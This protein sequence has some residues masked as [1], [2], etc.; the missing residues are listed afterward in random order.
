MKR[1]GGRAISLE[2]AL[3]GRTAL[4]TGASRGIG[5]AIARQLS[6]AG[7]RVALLA[8]TKPALEEIAEEIG[9]DAVVIESDLAS[10][11]SA[12]RAAA[13]LL[14]RFDG[15]PDILVNNAGIFSIV[16]LEQ[17]DVS[18]FS[19]MLE[20]NLLAPFI[21]L[22]AFLGPMRSRGSGHIVTIG[23]SA[24]RTI[25]P[26]NAAYSATKFGMRALHEVM[27]VETRGSG[28]RSTLVSPA[29]VDTDLWESIQ[30][31]DSGEEPDR[32][33]MMPPEAVADA[34]LYVLTRPPA[35]NIDELRLSPS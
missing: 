19:R 12:E 4:V 30:F 10:P 16:H 1:P 25:Y 23:S 6:A 29:G 31:P 27:R 17:M 34:V 15:A 8:R 22:R 7:A 35:I 9:N 14:K 20:T 26:G 28:I 33:R 3:D 21:L 18:G 2:T 32:S 13:G 24:D 11:A 5:A